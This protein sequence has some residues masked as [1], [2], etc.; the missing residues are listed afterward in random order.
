[1][2]RVFLAAQEDL[3]RKVALKVSRLR[4]MS[5][6]E[7]KA[8]GGLEHDHIVKVYS[9]FVDSATG[10]HCLCLQYIPGADLRAVIQR[11][12]PGGAVPGSGRDMLAAVDV[13]GRKDSAFDPAALRDREALA[14]DDF[15]Q[16]VCRLGGELA[17]ALA[18]AH[19]KG[20]LHCDIKP[21]NILLT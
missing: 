21:A 2:G 14:G 17:E 16:A 20:I 8:L 9:A 4:T 18:Y 10:W 1:F 5:A 13:A 19:A 11:L 3:N 12:F 7:G 15:A 6:E